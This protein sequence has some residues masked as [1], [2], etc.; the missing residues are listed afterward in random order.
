M[1]LTR[2]CAILLTC[3]SLAAC[4]L[5]QETAQQGAGLGV[6]LA[7][8]AATANPVIGLAA[9]V[10]ASWTTSTAMSYYEQSQLEALQEAIADATQDAAPGDVIG[11]AGGGKYGSL[12]VVRDFGVDTRCREVIFSLNDPDDPKVLVATVCN[13]EGEWRWAQPRPRP[14]LDSLF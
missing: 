11:W 12:E 2:R 10:I 3:A 9:G 1:H 14:D 8:G 7:A 4:S 5:G 13:Q 6:G